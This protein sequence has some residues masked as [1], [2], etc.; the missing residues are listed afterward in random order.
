MPLFTS[1]C[2]LDDTE[3]A[4]NRA[5]DN[6]AESSGTHPSTISTTHAHF[7]LLRLFGLGWGCGLRRVEGCKSVVS[8]DVAIRKEDKSKGERQ[9]KGGLGE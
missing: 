9:C 7:L 2:P 6:E 1:S 5:R 8:L 4:R 3:I